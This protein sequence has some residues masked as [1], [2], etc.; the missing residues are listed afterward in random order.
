VTV[1]ADPRWHLYRLLGDPV[2]LRLLALAGHE[3]LSV[4]ELAELLGESQPNVSRHAA[5][6]RQAGLLLVRRQGT[7]TLVRLADGAARDAVVADALQAGR[8]LCR[9]E[10]SLERVVDVVRARDARGRELFL[11]PS[12][13]DDP[14]SL[15]PELP[16]YLRAVGALLEHRSLALDAGTGDGALLDV[17]SPVFERVIA[18]DRSEIQL[19]RARRRLKSRG[20]GN[21]ELVR[22]EVDG[23]E[24]RRAVGEGAD[25][26]FASRMLHHAPVPRATLSALA[27]LA[28]PDG[29][30]VVLDYARHEDEA[31]RDEQADV[32]LGFEPDELAE[33]ARDVGLTPI[34]VAPLPA[35][36][37]KNAIDGHLGWLVFVASRAPLA[38]GT[39][40]APAGKRGRPSKSSPQNKEQR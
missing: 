37:V 31:L 30:L 23:P 4:G 10:G 40:A 14:P 2:R 29:R 32:W 25:V 38:P 15:P 21:V 18:L 11:R 35:S 9:E 33:Q 7:R 13:A 26:V 8:R 20:F 16:A 24:V 36:F 27:S 19:E 28:R 12:R 34:S 6:L 5:P 22:G 1:A 17:L 3:E 39:R